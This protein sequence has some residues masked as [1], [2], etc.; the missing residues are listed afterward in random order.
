MPDYY[1][2]NQTL[3]NI[4]QIARSFFSDC[5]KKTL[6][7]SAFCEDPYVYCATVPFST[8]ILSPQIPV[9]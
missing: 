3:V 5:N 8:A 9:G 6:Q 2:T 4:Q 7:R 1:S